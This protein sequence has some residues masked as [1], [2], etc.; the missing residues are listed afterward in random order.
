MKDQQNKERLCKKCKIIINL[1][2][3]D[4]YVSKYGQRKAYFCGIDCLINAI[5]NQF[6]ATYL[7]HKNLFD[8]F[9]KSDYTKINNSY[10]P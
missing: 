9:I 1:K 8:R 6:K 5:Q 4:Y 3:H 2:D 7:M 10:R